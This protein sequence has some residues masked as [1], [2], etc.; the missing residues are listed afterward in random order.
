MWHRAD[1]ES[2]PI[3]YAATQYLRKVTD[4]KVPT[5]GQKIHEYF[6]GLGIPEQDAWD[7]HVSAEHCIRQPYFATNSAV[8]DFAVAAYVLYSLK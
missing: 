2:V 5:L 4:F 8:P 7:L 6:V 1:Y 3:R